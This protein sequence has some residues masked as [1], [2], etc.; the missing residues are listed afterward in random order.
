MSEYS[1]PVL[2]AFDGS[3]DSRAAL[4]YAAAL[5]RGAPVTVLSVWEPL[6]VQAGAALSGMIVDPDVA[7]AGDAAVESATRELAERGAKLA[8]EA[9]MDSTPRWQSETRAV[10]STIVDVAD[11]LDARL[12]VT[13]SRGLSGLRSLLAGSVSGRV[14][15]EAHRPVLIVPGPRDAD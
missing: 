15:H 13:G 6:V 9:G 10:W 7:A 2:L 8:R 11:E 4:D 3:P 14:I 5:L 12:I 1:G